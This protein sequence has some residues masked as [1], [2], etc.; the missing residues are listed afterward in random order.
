MPIKET[1][2]MWWAGRSDD[3]YTI[4]PLPT[5]DDVIA[6]GYANFDDGFHI[7]EATKAESIPLSHFFDAD[8]WLENAEDSAFDDFGSHEH[9]APVF[10]L[11]T[12]QKVVFQD[13]VRA[14][15]DKFQADEKLT[16]TGFLFISQR[17]E[18]Y[19]SQPAHVDAE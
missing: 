1:D 11:S 4:G 6:E 7:V 10:D 17:N 19:I 2:W 18:E 13:A 3:I 15:M 8:C 12:G 5:R 16:F 14:A 9:D